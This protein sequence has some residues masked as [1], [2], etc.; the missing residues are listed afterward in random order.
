MKTPDRVLAHKPPRIATTLV[1]VAAVISLLVPMSLH[2]ALPLAAIATGVT[3]FAIMIRAWWL[4]RIEATAICP[5]ADTTTLITGDIYAVS[6]NP[7]YLGMALMLVAPAMLTGSAA[8]YI[9]AAA[10]VLVI[11][12]HFITFEEDKLARAFGEHFRGY[13]KRVRRWL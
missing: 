7:M 3:G 2:T 13:R 4:F 5:T 12:R 11:D 1:L 8:F 9:A 10:F 6:R